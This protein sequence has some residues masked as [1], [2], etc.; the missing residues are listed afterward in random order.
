MDGGAWTA[1]VHGIAG[2]RTWLSETSL[3]LFTF[4][5]RRRK[6]HPT[7][8]LLPGESHGWRSLEG[9]SPWDRGGS[10]MTERD[11]TFTFHFHASE[12]E[13][14][15]HSSVLAWRI[16]GM[17]EPDGLPSLGSHR[18]GH[19]WSDLAAAAAAWPCYKYDPL[20]ANDVFLQINVKVI[21]MVSFILNQ[22]VILPKTTGFQ[23]KIKFQT[24][25]F[26]T[27]FCVEH[28]VLLECYII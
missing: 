16:P 8:V 20:A 17:G 5:H 18:V 28:I 6:W 7:P 10:D 21:H 13:M 27:L 24:G 2:G 23:R 3:S 4:M 14:A 1:A 12:E 9:C 25:N 19:D 15:T 11:F 26:Y 22:W